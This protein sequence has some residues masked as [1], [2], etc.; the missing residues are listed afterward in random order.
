MSFTSNNS[1]ILNSDNQES[2]FANVNILSENSALKIDKLNNSYKFQGSVSGYVSGG[3]ISPSVTNVIEKFSFATDG[4]AT[5][6]GDLTQARTTSGQSSSVSGYSTAGRTA[7]PPF[8]FSFSTRRD[9]FPFATDTNSSNIGDSLESSTGNK[10]HSSSAH[11]YSSAGVIERTDS[12]DVPSGPAPQEPQTN[13]AIRITR[14]EKFPF[15]TDSDVMGTSNLRTVRSGHSEHSSDVSGYVGGGDSPAPPAEPPFQATRNIEKF[16]FSF[17]AVATSVGDLLNKYSALSGQ[18]STVSGYSSGAFFIPT[19]GS[20]VNVIQKF[21]FSTDTNASDVGD[22]TEARHSA[23]GQSSTVSGYTSGGAPSV[24]NTIDKF[25]F[26]TDTNA[27][28]VGDL[29]EAKSGGAGHQI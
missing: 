17:D 20:T 26:S 29:T 21:P 1:I 14:V 18:S 24:R 23:S 16:P 3:F 19:P 25:P 9:K 13:R 8:T 15:A 11:G 28:D 27:S 7:V 12:F 2:F 5:D 22:L 6:V 4:N 10:G